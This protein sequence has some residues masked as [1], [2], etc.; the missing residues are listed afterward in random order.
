MQAMIAKV[1]EWIKYYAAMAAATYP[2]EQGLRKIYTQEVALQKMGEI[3]EKRGNARKLS[4]DS[5][6]AR[7]EV[8]ASKVKNEMIPNGSRVNDDAKLLL[9]GIAFDD[10]QYLGMLERNKGNYT[11]QALIAAHAKANGVAVTTYGSE[12]KLRA[13]AEIESLA[14][15]ALAEIDEAYQG[16]ASNKEYRLETVNLRIEEISKIQG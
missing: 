13:L 11:M 10:Q 6:R 9:P 2:E 3:Q 12:E 1:V 8:E 7:I 14:R 5:I 15:K 4:L 16:G